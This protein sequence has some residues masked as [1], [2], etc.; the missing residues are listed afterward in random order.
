MLWSLL[1]RRSK[2]G[3]TSGRIPRYSASSAA[4]APGPVF[5]ERCHPPD[6]SLTSV[7]SSVRGRRQPAVTPRLFGAFPRF[8]RTFVT[9]VTFESLGVAEP[10]LR[11]LAAENYTHPTPIQAQAIPALLAGRDLLG[12]AQTGTGKTAA[13]GLPLLQ[14]LSIGHVPPGPKQAGADPGAD[15][16][17]GGADRAIPAHLWPLPESEADRDPGRREPEQPGP[18]PWRTAWTFWWRR[19]AACSTW[20]SRSMCGWTR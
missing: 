19:P 15:P 8:L 12:I 20:C 11:A 16:R 4:T 13:F 9:D 5:L 10:I 6:L 14:K 3:L 1:L 17:T 18:Q 7:P 2:I